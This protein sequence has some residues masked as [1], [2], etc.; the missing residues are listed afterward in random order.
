MFH[1]VPC[2]LFEAREY[3][4]RELLVTK[5]TIKRRGSFSKVC[6]RIGRIREGAYK[7]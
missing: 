1:P 3:Y 5:Y 7:L 4:L 6:Q 2:I